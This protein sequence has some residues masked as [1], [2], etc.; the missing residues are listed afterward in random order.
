MIFNL[1]PKKMCK[2]KTTT[3]SDMEP[4]VA[5][6]ACHISTGEAEAR[7]QGARPPKKYF[8]IDVIYDS[9]I[10]CFKKSNLL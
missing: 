2:N 8:L 6:H 9:I 4:R 10:V 5:A 7:L 1:S 3:K